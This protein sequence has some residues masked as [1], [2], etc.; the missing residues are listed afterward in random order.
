MSET[1]KLIELLDMMPEAVFFAEAGKVSAMNRAGEELCGKRTPEDILPEEALAGCGKKKLIAAEINGRPADISIAPLEG[2]SVISVQ[3]EKTGADIAAFTRALRSPAGNLVLASGLMR[4]VAEFIG[5]EEM[6]QYT[7]MITRDSLRIKRVADN[8]ELFERL[9]TGK[10]AFNAVRTDV[11]AFLRELTDTAAELAAERRI[12]VDFSCEDGECFAETD[13][14]LFETAMLQLLSNALKY[15]GSGGNVRVTLKPLGEKLIIAVA[16]SGR[17]FSGRALATAFE[18]WREEPPEDEPERGAGLGLAIAS[19]I[20]GMHGGI[21][22]AENISSGALATIIIPKAPKR[23][24]T[25]EQSIRSDGGAMRK[26]LTQLSDALGYK[27]Y[28]SKYL[29]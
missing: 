3:L 24:N 25:E 19:A 26:I 14:D 10:C 11:A 2:G 7:A 21:A 1:K 17:G 22:V 23:G 12:A 5:N 29:D 15:A 6:E 28:I 8:A 16:D 18:A 20:A 13:A 27:N 9:K 4:P